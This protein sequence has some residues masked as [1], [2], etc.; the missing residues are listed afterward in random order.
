MSSNK[1]AAVLGAG[2]S[3]GMA[4]TVETVIII[5][6]ISIDVS[7]KSSSCSQSRYYMER[8]LAIS[9]FEAAFAYG[10]GEECTLHGAGTTDLKCTIL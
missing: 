4:G 8:Q 3:S 6:T 7:M 5:P 10:Q 2:R 9:R 1:I